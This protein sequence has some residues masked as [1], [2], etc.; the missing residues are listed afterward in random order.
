MRQTIG[1]KMVII[2]FILLVFSLFGNLNGVGQTASAQSEDIAYVL[3]EGFDSGD[4]SIT[5]NLE[6]IN[7]FVSEKGNYQVESIVGDSALKL[8]KSSSSGET[9]HYHHTKLK[10]STK[11]RIQYRAK[12]GAANQNLAYQISGYK[13]NVPKD[14]KLALNYIEHNSM[15]NTDWSTFY[16][17]FETSEEGTSAWIQFQTQAG[18]TAWIDDITIEEKGQADPLLTKPTLSR[19]SKRFIENGLQIQ[20]W[21]TTDEDNKIRAWKKPP[22][23]EDIVDLGI[24]AVQYNDAPNYS[25]GLHERYAKLQETTP[26]LPDLKWGMAFA[27]NANHLS[28]N[29]FDSDTIAKHE[30]NRT[31]APTKEQKENGFLTKNQLENVENLINIGFGDEENYSDTLTQILKDWF[32]VTKKFYPNVL[33]H[34]NEVGNTPPANITSISTFNEEMLR[35]YVRTAKPDF[36]TYDMYYFRENRQSQEV[37]GTVIPFYDDINRYRKI[38]AEGYDGTGLSPIPFGNYMQ[39]WRT[40]PGAAT[41]EKRGDGWYEMTESQTYLSGFANWTFGGKWLSIFRW[42]KDSPIYLFT[43]SRVDENGNPIPYHIYDQTKELIRQ[44]R[45]IGDHLTRLNS[46]EVSILPGQHMEGEKAVKNSRPKDNPE[47]NKSLDQAFIDNIDVKN[48]GPTNDGLDGDVFIGYF[49]PLPG[50]DTTEFFTSTSPKYFMILNGL[51]HGNGLPAEEQMGSSYETRQEIHVTFDLSEG[52]NPTKLRKVSRLTGEIEA[53]PLKVKE[54][55]KYEMTLTIGG[56]MADLYFWEL[57][58]INKDNVKQIKEETTEDIRLTGDPKYAK[59]REIRDLGG[60]TVTIGWINGTESPIPQ[61][62]NH[63]DFTFNKDASGKLLPLANPQIMS[64]FTRYYEVNIWN[65]RV[66]RIQRESNVDIQFV[67]DIKWSKE[68]LME[69]IRKKKAGQ[70]VPNMPDILVVPDEW[71]WTGLI[72]DDMI[73]PASSFDEFDFSDRKWNKP[74]KAMTTYN[75][76]TYGMYAGPTMNSVGLF[77]NK[78][79][80]ADIGFSE[81]LMGIQQNEKW[82]WDKLQEIIE[83]FE[84]SSNA[85]NKYVFA[86][87]EQL[88]KQMLYSNNAAPESLD[89]LDGNTFKFNTT[90]FKQAAQLYHQLYNGDLIAEKPEAA[91]ED[92]DI[93]EF[94]KGNVLFL[95]KPYNQTVEQLRKEY[96]VQDA[97]IEMQDGYF[98]GQPAKIPVIVDAFETVYPD[99]QHVMP[100]DDW[101]FLFF[102]KGPS[103]IDYTA[104][105]DQP[106]YPVML[107][108]AKDPS[109][110]AYVWN[111]LSE[112]FTGVEYTRFLRKYLNQRTADKTTLQRIGLKNGVWDAYEGTGTWNNV[113]APEFMS[114]LKKGNWKT[115]DLAKLNNKV[116]KNVEDNVK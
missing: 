82:N 55:G 103:A 39:G 15:K 26:G 116:R 114:F 14:V 93:E 67:P 72:K 85:K 96:K 111:Q 53:V 35:K 62:L 65:R 57:G 97:V 21:V 87:T 100:S 6:A 86:D 47:W 44:S 89:N 52:I 37:G 33:V 46:T 69:N 91:K 36:I 81:N 63:F 4:D 16:Y 19:A 23:P 28:S 75:N 8:G 43:D 42:I 80:L 18:S 60:R 29:Y 34:H 48:L 22:T 95:V 71:T 106:S 112:E 99:G 88:F 9:I 41:H 31:G 105:I 102:P 84:K 13:N 94:S 54:N 17:D 32:D 109:D 59:D 61:P 40:G 70:S 98:L 7:Q 107:S 49:D 45:N 73:L 90:N 25:K 10:P 11:Y 58:S 38:A 110:V 68:E 101:Q 64:Y 30:P 1:S 50:F 79:L 113:M 12:V 27:P 20:T 5:T 108:S 24:T 78:K 76:Q 56:G 77:V 51:T 104:I 3:N 2:T 74:Y 83:Q 66:E 115:S 92:W